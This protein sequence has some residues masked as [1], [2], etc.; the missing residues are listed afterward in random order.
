MLNKTNFAFFRLETPLEHLISQEEK[1][2]I[3][4]T[5]ALEKSQTDLIMEYRQEECYYQEINHYYMAPF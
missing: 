5:K 2:K 3:M 1:D 4:N